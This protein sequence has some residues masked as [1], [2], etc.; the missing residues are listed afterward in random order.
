MARRAAKK[1]NNHNSIKAHLEAIGCVCA[2]CH[3]HGDGFPDLFVYDPVCGLVWLAE[4][5]STKYNKLTPLEKKLFERF[6]GC[7]YVV[8]WKSCE[9]AQLDIERARG[10]E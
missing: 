1:D 4:I 8:I 5:K 3:R 7:R 6:D 2:D 9:D 10:V